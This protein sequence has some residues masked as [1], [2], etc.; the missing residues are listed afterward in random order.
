MKSQKI[1]CLIALFAGANALNMSKP[2][3]PPVN[4]DDHGNLVEGT[5][6]YSEFEYSGK[7]GWK[8][9]DDPHMVNE[10]EFVDAV[11]QEFKWAMKLNQR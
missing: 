5:P 2:V 3:N 8:Y 6:D 1:I 4:L 9:S 7:K 10:K 11:P